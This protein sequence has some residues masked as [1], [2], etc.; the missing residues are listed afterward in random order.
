LR[1]CH[2]AEEKTGCN[3]TLKQR[4]KNSTGLLSFLTAAFPVFHVELQ[5][6]VVTVEFI[7]TV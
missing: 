3:W 4:V 7:A 5:G 6:F 1:L 2:R